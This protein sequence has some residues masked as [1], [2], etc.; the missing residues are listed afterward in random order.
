MQGEKGVW[1]LD[2][3]GYYSDADVRPCCNLGTPKPIFKFQFLA[4]KSYVLPKP[5]CQTR[6]PLTLS[7]EIHSPDSLVL[8]LL[9]LPLLLLL[10]CCSFCCSA[11]A[12]ADAAATAGILYPLSC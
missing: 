4:I 2:K 1:Q 12:A 9:L 5:F 7:Y 3:G 6:N 8:L 10:L 11:A